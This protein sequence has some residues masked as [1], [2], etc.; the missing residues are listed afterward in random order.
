[1]KY[2]LILLLFAACTALLCV[3]GCSVQ[4]RGKRR[5]LVKVE[6]IKGSL[7]LSTVQETEESKDAD[8]TK[9]KSESSI[10]VQELFF[11]AEGDV[12]DPKLLTYM[13]GLGLG[14]EKQT[15]KS[16]GTT[17]SSSG[18]VDSYHVGM[19]LLSSK[20]YPTS[21]STEKTN[22][23]ITRRFQGP[24]RI[25][26]TS[27]T[28]VTR[29][30]VPQW[31][32]IFSWSSSE[33]SQKSDVGTNFDHFSRASDKF[34]YSVTHDFSE[35]SHLDFRTDIE[36]LSYKGFSRD[37][38]TTRHR[39]LHDYYF[40]SDGQHSLNS[41]VY[42][43]DKEG[44]FRSETLNWSESLYLS[45]SKN[46]STFHNI[47]ASKI[48][49]ENGENQTIGGR[50]GF[51]HRLYDN[52]TTNFSLYANKTDFGSDSESR[53][54]GGNL[55]FGYTRN[56][57]L[58]KLNSSYSINIERTKNSGA[59]GTNVVTGESHVFVALLPSFML[60][61]RNIVVD[62]IVV[63]NNAGDETY[64]EGDDYTVSVIGDQV[65]LTVTDLGTDLPNISDGQVLLVDYIFDVEDS[66]QEDIVTQFFRIEQK[67]TNG[68]SAF[69][70]HRRRDW[71]VDSEIG[72][73]IL[74]RGYRND[75]FGIEYRN[76][77]I[78]L[79]ARHSTTE[80]DEN[81][82]QSDVGRVSQSWIESSRI[83]FRKTSLFMAE[84]DISTR[85]TRYL[86]LSGNIEL[87]EEDNSDFGRTDGLT[88]GAALEYNRRA[89]SV[90]A[91][92]ENHV[93]EYPNR[94]RDSSR[95]YFNLIRR[96]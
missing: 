45:H 50:T 83:D 63:T 23:F 29:L 44:G 92:W 28:I 8:G 49:F 78:Y 91:G 94:R 60:D 48:T 25:E 93:F 54:H 27:E 74:D 65:E 43:L 84:G 64:T 22:N 46:F 56:N 62:T 67:F 79:S 69:Y 70:S 19:N 81:S 2:V 90:K 42:Y 68:V 33:I 40:G 1:M 21:I 76:R 11:G 7:R 85:P 3:G 37:T 15:L 89:L 55:R 53:G 9:Q 10:T 20:P 5:P 17:D 14:L 73:A 82:I 38:E 57:P 41:S 4:V 59:T 6:D 88:F 35:R 72:A 75:A 80:S 12:F 26:S 13:I 51:N 58:G 36:N 96:F 95:F 71:E 52:L 18:E 47:Y 39:L 32:M 34:S 77:Y 66:R 16:G 30:R 61:E 24:L 86:R 31:P 87:R